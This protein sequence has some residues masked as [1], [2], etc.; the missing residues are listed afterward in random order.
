MPFPNRIGLIRVAANNR[1]SFFVGAL[2][3]RDISKSTLNTRV[4]FSGIENPPTRALWDNTE[5]LG[6]RS[7]RGRLSYK[8]D[9]FLN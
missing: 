8:A 2:C 9:L 6:N 7:Y 1:Y 5:R 3:K 4:V